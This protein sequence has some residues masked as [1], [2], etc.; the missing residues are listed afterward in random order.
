MIKGF[1]GRGKR[2]NA[3]TDQLGKKEQ[4]VCT[5]AAHMPATKVT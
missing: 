2:R 5:A 1:D 4:D 3:H